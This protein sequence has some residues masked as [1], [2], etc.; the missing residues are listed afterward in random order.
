MGADKV[1]IRTLM[2]ELRAVALN[3][4][5]PLITRLDAAIARLKTATEEMEHSGRLLS[6]PTIVVAHVPARTD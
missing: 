5:L 2:T 4:A 6:K 3:E 1:E